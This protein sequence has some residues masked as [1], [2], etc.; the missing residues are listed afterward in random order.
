[1]TWKD[2]SLEF[3]CSPVHELAHDV[4]RFSRPHIYID[5][6]HELQFDSCKPFALHLRTCVCACVCVVSCWSNVVRVSISNWFLRMALNSFIFQIGSL[7]LSQLKVCSDVNDTHTKPIS[8]SCCV[9]TTVR[10]QNI[11][12]LFFEAEQ[13]I[14]VCSIICLF[15]PSAQTGWG[16]LSLK[17]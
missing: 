16:K 13:F 7:K 12:R 5:Y 2:F 9:S 11:L 10:V 14:T 1:M 4:F 3:S 8:A 17:V 6:E 15:L